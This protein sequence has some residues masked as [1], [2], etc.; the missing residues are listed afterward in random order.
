VT[1]CAAEQ[2]HP[3]KV[4]RMR[5]LGANVVLF[6]VDFDEARAEARRVAESA[7]RG[8][9][10]TASMSRRSKAP[11][12]LASSFRDSSGLSTFSWCPSGTVRCATGLPR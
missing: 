11:G 2:A 7:A 9:S 6:G 12:R 4:E 5:A 3:L 1:V 8:W 10:S